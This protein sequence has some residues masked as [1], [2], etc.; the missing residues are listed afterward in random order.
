[1]LVTVANGG[2]LLT[3]TS[4]LG[5][6]LVLENPKWQASSGM[7]ASKVAG[8]MPTQTR[9]PAALAIARD[10]QGSPRLP[11]IGR[12]TK[13]G[14]GCCGATSATTST[15]ATTLGRADDDA[16]AKTDGVNILSHAQAKAKALG[17]WWTARRPSCTASRSGRRWNYTST[18]KRAVGQSVGDVVNRSAVHI[19]PDLGDLVVAELT[20]E[21]L[22]RWLATMAATPAQ[23]RS[24]GGQAE[25][26]A[27]AGH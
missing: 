26:Q 3:H 23:T 21:R 1:M 13:Q 22:R 7:Q 4:I 6:S 5:P 25:I 12:A 15:G 27:G 17:Y 14:A 2:T 8:A 19:L 11:N 10:R 18:Q 20:A 24:K 9:S 16:E